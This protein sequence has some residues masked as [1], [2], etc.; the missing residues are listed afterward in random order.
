MTTREPTFPDTVAS[1]APDPLARTRPAESVK[2]PVPSPTDAAATATCPF[3]RSEQTRRGSDSPDE[4]RQIHSTRGCAVCGTHFLWPQPDDATLTR[5]YA[6]AYYGAG[7]TKFGGP[8][9]RFRDVASTGRARGFLRQLPADG[10]VLDIGCGDG[11]LLRQ[12]KRLNPKLTL[13]GVE[14]PGPAAERAAA[15]PGLQLH[16]GTVDTAHYPEASFDLITL[17]HV[18]EHLPDP[19]RALETIVRWLKPGGRLF[20][21]FP[22]I[23]SWQARWSGPAWFHLD[24]PRHL[25]LTPPQ[26]FTEF[27]QNH[28]VVT[29]RVRHWCP[30]QN[31]Y[32]WLQSAL[33]RW[34][35]DR[36]FLYER[37][38]R[39][40]HYAAHRKVAVLGHAAA[41]AALLPFATAVDAAAAL[42][43]A[44][45]T[46]EMTFRKA[47]SPHAA[48]TPYSR[49][50]H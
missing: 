37:L 3:C 42:A 18:I 38:K 12:L 39:N 49:A 22:N 8:I 34:D 10:A 4:F 7:R 32:G 26:T 21:A 20:L 27:L 43:G 41:A 31:L 13:H 29:E 1:D 44:G 24:P 25:T 15:T 33:N 11:R 17:V 36:N 40:R 16:L 6:V 14:L 48:T 35:P 28:G 46:V 9:E 19:R 50:G 47:I 23:A 5:A 45:A 2:P 30:E